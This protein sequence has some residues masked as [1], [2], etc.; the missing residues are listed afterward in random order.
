MKTK[1]NETKRTESQFVITFFDRWG[2]EKNP[3]EEIDM[4]PFELHCLSISKHAKPFDMAA[5]VSFSAKK[6]VSSHFGDL[7]TS[8]PP[9]KP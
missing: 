7:W 8:S 6:R 2:D 4:A 9:R 3:R 1:R 5:K